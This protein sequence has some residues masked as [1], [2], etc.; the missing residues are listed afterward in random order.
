VE[1]VRT[2]WEA[3]SPTTH[4]ASITSRI[5]PPGDG[6]T[7]RYGA[8]SIGHALAGRAAARAR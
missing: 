5:M 4:P 8:K 3:D 1:T 7:E 2:R 6:V